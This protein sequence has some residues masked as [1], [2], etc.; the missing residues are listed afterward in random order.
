MGLDVGIVTTLR[1][2]EDETLDDHAHVQ[3]HHLLEQIDA[4]VCE[5]G[6]YFRRVFTRKNHGC[7]TNIT[8]NGPSLEATC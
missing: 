1:V 4:G 2:T 7:L 3:S 6:R 8:W 5:C